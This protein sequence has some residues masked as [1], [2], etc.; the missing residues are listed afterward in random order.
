MEIC[1]EPTLKLRSTQY[2]IRV[3]FTLKAVGLI[4]FTNGRLLI[5]DMIAER[6]QK[7]VRV[8]V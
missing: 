5:E 7:L 3:L 1:F 6:P 4:Y 8:S 2:E